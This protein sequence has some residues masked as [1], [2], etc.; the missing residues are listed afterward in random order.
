VVDS[1]FYRAFEDRFRGSRELVKLRLGVYLPFIAPLK[2]FGSSPMALDLGCG[3]GEWLE[4]LQDQ[5]FQAIGVDADDAMLSGCR[6]LKLNTFHSDFLEWLKGVESDSQSVVSAFHFVEHIPFERLFELVKEAHRVLKPGGLLILE[7]QNSENLLVGASTFYIDPTHQRPIHPLQLS[8]I[9]E[10][11]GFERIKTLYLQESPE[12]AAAQYSNLF[13]VLNGVSP[14]YAV[15]AQK[16][17]GK[18][19]A[20]LF[21]SCFEC[22]YGLRLNDLAGRYDQ[23]VDVR[24]KEVNEHK[25]WLQSEWHNAQAKVEALNYQNGSLKTE[26]QWLQ[27]QWNIAQARAAELEQRAIAAEAAAQLAEAA[28]IAIHKSSSWLITAP[29]RMVSRAA[30]PPF[31]V[32]AVVKSKTGGKSRMLLEHATLYINRRPKLQRIALAVLT[33]F[34]ALKRRLKQASIAASSTQMAPKL[35]DL[36]PPAYRIYSL[37]KTAIE[38]HKRENK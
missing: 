14:D 3:R 18:E 20:A 35:A 8:F 9:A 2:T 34:P 6:E 5:G 22:S 7:T 36:T 26:I 10:Y 37:L 4:L 13:S 19:I 16:K 30:K 25:Q 21:D 33:L 32:L 23:H 15:V 24:I 17:A 12:L 11:T 38:S 1:N 29:L 31:C 27:S 28:L